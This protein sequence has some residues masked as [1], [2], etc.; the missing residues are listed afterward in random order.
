MASGSQS[1]ASDNFMLRLSISEL[2]S[3]LGDI[4]H[5][6][7]DGKERDIEEILNSQMTRNFNKVYHYPRVPLVEVYHWC[8]DDTFVKDQIANNSFWSRA[9]ECCGLFPS[10]IV[11]DFEQTVKLEVKTPLNNNVCVKILKGFFETQKR[12]MHLGLVQIAIRPL[13]R[14]RFLKCSNKS[15]FNR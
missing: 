12:V 5:K 10:Y 3:L 7:F 11:K 9:K 4:M 14:E 13:R 1:N 8:I 15:L 6:V 2:T